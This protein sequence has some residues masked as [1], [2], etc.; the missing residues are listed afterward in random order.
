MEKIT[1]DQKEVRLIDHVRAI[2]RQLPT[3]YYF[4]IQSITDKLDAAGLKYN[5]GGLKGGLIHT[6]IRQGEIYRDIDKEGLVR[7]RRNTQKKGSPELTSGDALVKKKRRSPKPHAQISP[8][9]V[10]LLTADR[11]LTTHE[12]Q[13]R[14]DLHFNKKIGLP[15]IHQLTRSYCAKGWLEHRQNTLVKGHLKEYMA[16]ADL[17]DLMRPK[18]ERLIGF[19]PHLA[20]EL[21]AAFEAAGR[22]NDAVSKE[23]QKQKED[24]ENLSQS[25]E[26]PIDWELPENYFAAADL[27]AA[28][29][30]YMRRLNRQIGRAPKGQEAEKMI[31]RLKYD[32]DEMR[33]RIFTKTNQVNGLEREKN[34][35]TI[36]LDTVLKENQDLKDE[37]QNI[38]VKLNQMKGRAPKGS[39]K[40]S[41]V[42]NIKRLAENEV[43]ANDGSTR[44]TVAG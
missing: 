23:V 3:K 36:R 20:D 7:Y 34:R 33:A 35:L 16:T 31:A 40:L 13:A 2:I 14:V 6:L 28:M 9:L 10:V 5:R 26:N 44:L 18:I 29:F 22:K 38:R 19:A 41:E 27:G 15:G 1:E 4:T 39:F 11:F 43:E 8:T 37:M 30:D 25:M 17:F 42:A 12:I 32:I 24:R 21:N